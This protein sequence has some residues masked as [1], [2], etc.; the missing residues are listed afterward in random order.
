MPPRPRMLVHHSPDNF[1]GMGGMRDG[2]AFGR[3]YSNGAQADQL[4][5]ESFRQELDR[6]GLVALA[7]VVAMLDAK[8]LPAQLEQ[9]AFPGFITAFGVAGAVRLV[10]KNP[11]ARYSFVVSN[12]TNANLV[13]MSYGKPLDMGG[14][15]GAGVLVSPCFEETYG[16]VS[17]DELWM[18]CNDSSGGTSFPVPVVAFEGGISIAGNRP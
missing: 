15:I 2:R 17:I 14:G 10:P 5:L 9:V 16:A 6:Q 3:A 7:D 18:F 13:C 11:I 12:F 4:S 1:P 8:N